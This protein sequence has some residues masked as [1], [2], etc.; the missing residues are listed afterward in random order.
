MFGSHR[1]VQILHHISKN[2]AYLMFCNFNKFEPTLITFAIPKLEKACILLPFYLIF[3]Y[4]FIYPAPVPALL[5][6]IISVHAK[7]WLI[8]VK[9]PS[10]WNKLPKLI[11]NL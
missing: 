1:S 6:Y 8:C 7:T 2:V 3:T 5:P 9:R 11:Q 4:L 10:A